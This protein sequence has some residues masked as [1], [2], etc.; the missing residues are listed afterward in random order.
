LLSIDLV[1]GYVDRLE[2]LDAS[3]GASKALIPLA[4][5][6]TVVQSL[7]S[8]DGTASSVFVTDFSSSGSDIYLVNIRGNAPVQKEKVFQGKS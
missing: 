2:V 8:A 5:D 6:V 1:I 4:P 7:T 3:L